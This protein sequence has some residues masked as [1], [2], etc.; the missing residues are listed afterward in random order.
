M[1]WVDIC[2]G[3]AGTGFVAISRQHGR[4]R[5]APTAMI[6]RRSGVAQ[7]GQVVPY[8]GGVVPAALFTVHS[9]SSGA[10]PLSE[11]EARSEYILFI[12]PR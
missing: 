11:C 7:K 3:I 2:Q 12:S 9:G 6:E 8:L 4:P 1:R 5:T 10:N